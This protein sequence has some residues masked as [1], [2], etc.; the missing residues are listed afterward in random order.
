M[1]MP[2]S[3]YDLVCPEKCHSFLSFKFLINEL[4]LGTQPRSQNLTAPNTTVTFSL[5]CID[6]DV[7]SFQAQKIMDLFSYNFIA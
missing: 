4:A 2:I 5:H 1:E 7:W 6:I 3:S